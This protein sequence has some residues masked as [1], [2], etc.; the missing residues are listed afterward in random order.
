M[1]RLGPSLRDAVV[2]KGGDLA[3][4]SEIR[5]RSEQ[6]GQSQ[7]PSDWAHRR[8]HELGEITFE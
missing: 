6:S 8:D 7:S 5:H 4:D 3:V 2:V 1:Q